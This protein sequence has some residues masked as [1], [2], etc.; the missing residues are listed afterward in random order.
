MFE[1]TVVK[2]IEGQ[3]RKTP[4]ATALKFEEVSLTFKTFVEY[5]NILANQ[6]KTLGV[7]PEIKVGIMLPR[8]MELII[9]MYGILKSG[10][11]FTPINPYDAMDRIS[12]I[13]ND[14]GISVLITFDEYLTDEIKN[15]D[16]SLI[17][18]KLKKNNI[19]SH[20]IIKTKEAMDSIEGNAKGD[21]SKNL[22]YVIYTSGTTGK[23]KGVMIEHRNLFALMNNYIP[24]IDENDRI[25][26]SMSPTFDGCLYQIFPSLCFGSTL[27]LWKDNI[28]HA[29]KKE[30]ISYTSI[31]PSMI[32]L[33]G[34]DD[35]IHL[36]K[37]ITTGEKL[38]TEV[39]A[40]FPSSV[41]IYNGYGPTEATIATTITKITDSKKIH[42]GGM[43]G[44]VVLYIVNKEM[45]LCKVGEPGELLIGGEGVG[46][47]YLN[48]PELT[49]EKFIENP[50]GEGRLYKS[51][52]LVQWDNDIELNFLG[53][54]DRQIKLRGYRLELDGI[55]STISKFPGIMGVFCKVYYNSLVAHV[56]PENIN[57]EDLKAFL[58]DKLSPMAIPGRIITHYKFPL[59]SSG[60]VDD[61][62]LD[63]SFVIEDDEVFIPLDDFEKNIAEIWKRS[64]VFYKNENRDVQVNDNFF[65]LGGNSI[66]AMS[67]IA[68]IQKSLKSNDVPLGLIYENPTIKIFCQSLRNRSENDHEKVKIT[69]KDFLDFIRVLPTMAIDAIS[70]LG[71]PFLLLALCFVNP[72][73]LVI[74]PIEILLNKT[75]RVFSFNFL[76]KISNFLNLNRFLYKDVEILEE[77]PI[78]DKRSSLIC[79][80]PHGLTSHHCGFLINYLLKRNIDFRI[81]FDAWDFK[82]PLNFTY[83]VFKGLV[84]A[85]E[86]TYRWAFENNISLFV[87]PGDTPEYWETDNPNTMVLTPNKSFFKMA[88]KNGMPIVPIYV[89]NLHKSFKTYPNLMKIRNSYKWLKSIFNIHFFTGR[90][91][92]PIPFKTNLRYAIGK[93]IEVGKNENP[94]W[95]EVDE[96]VE[97][98]SKAY[99][100]LFNRHKSVED[101]DLNIK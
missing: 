59:T 74:Y 18:V 29:I 55:E 17:K 72:L 63:K 41:E 84:P 32:E 64:I 34:P 82:I 50:F 25:L 56:V 86:K 88:L 96:L 97:K 9:S 37:I 98:Y 51:G 99:I 44:H 62:A 5:S 33:F 71:R 77:A 58:K 66:N 89:Y 6:L 36:K 46:R 70:V 78:S 24:K 45:K 60:K 54:I 80:H 28:S 57:G 14:S 48:R 49:K 2:L 87:T 43:Y 12:Y 67:L 65:D 31:T 30:K 92:L 47:G 101:S 4:S 94:S 85:S 39:A 15:F 73:F 69:F 11:A 13:I 100:E 22:A 42:I 26:Q 10:G 16:L 61:K 76:F 38:I 53:R 7:G 83:N 68:E 27:V 35:L 8:S 95:K 52:D 23:P 21:I 75:G 19:F 81:T 40:K 91:G 1:G 20:K 90:L 93:T 3:A 79:L